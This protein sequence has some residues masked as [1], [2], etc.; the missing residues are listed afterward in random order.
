MVLDI[1]TTHSKSA[2]LH[3]NSAGNIAG[4]GFRIHYD[5][6]EESPGKE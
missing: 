6:A 5:F 4:V 1:L 2:R 3:F